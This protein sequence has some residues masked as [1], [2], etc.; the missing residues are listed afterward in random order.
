MEKTKRRIV[1]DADVG[2]GAADP[3]QVSAGHPVNSDALGQCFGALHEAQ[4]TA[5]FSPALWSEWLDHAGHGATRWL[6]R[7]RDRGLLDEFKDQP[8][9]TALLDAIVRGLLVVER[10][11]ADKDVHQVATAVTKADNRLISRDAK[12]RSQFVLVAMVDAA[13]KPAPD[14]R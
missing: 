4:H 2:R 8:N 6:A 1:V 10:P 13:A 3:A 11:A 14:S 9:Q 7:M 5:V 12:G